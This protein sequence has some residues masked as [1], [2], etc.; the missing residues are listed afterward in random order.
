MKTSA[1]I[2][3]PPSKKPI[4]VAFTAAIMIHLCAVALASHRASPSAETV[5]TFQGELVG[6]EEPDVPPAPEVETM[7]EAPS[8]SVPTDFVEPSLQPLRSINRNPKPIRPV[9]KAHSGATS[10]GRALALTA[11]TPEYPYEARRRNIT[12][13]GVVALTVDETSG[14]VIDAEMEPGT[15]SSI[16]DQSALRGLRR[17][18]FKAGAP[19]RVRVPITFTITGAQF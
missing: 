10:N 14:A 19:R 12:S 6:I 13:S 15:G 11:P 16:L 3:R 7:P 2:Y 1:L 8:F 17:W 9:P 5:P 18:R 4:A